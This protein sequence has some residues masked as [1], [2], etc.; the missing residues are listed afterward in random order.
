MQSPFRRLAIPIAWAVGV[1]LVIYGSSLGNAYLIHH[2]VPLAEQDR[3]GTALWFVLA[4]TIECALLWIILRPATYRRSWG[5]ALGAALILAVCIVGF[6][7]IALHAP[8]ALVFHVYWLLAMFAGCLALLVTSA[9]ASIRS[10]GTS[11]R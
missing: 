10:R 2:K 11:D 7:E 5:R 9:V 4:V 8:A 1:L 3:V 6:A